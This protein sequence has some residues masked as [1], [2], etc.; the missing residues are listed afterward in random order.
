MLL[1]A[2]TVLALASCGN[3][4]AKLSG[5]LIGADSR[6]IT[7]EM[8]SPGGT[9]TVDTISTDVK[10]RYSFTVK[11]PSQQ[12]TLYNLKINGE[13]IPLFISPGERITVNT[14]FA[15]PRRYTVNGSPES[16]LL[17]EIND[18][19]RNG[20]TRLDS[21]ANA[22]ASIANNEAELEQNTQEYV[23]EYRSTKREHV[24]FIIGNK[25]RLAAVY[26]LNQRMP[27]DEV[28]FAGENDIVYYRTVA[29]EVSRTYP[30]SPYV[31][32]LKREIAAY[33]SSVELAGQLQEKI[34]NPDPF[35]EIAMPDIYGKEQKLSQMLGKV[36]VLDFWSLGFEQAAVV[37]AE[38]RE[39][40]GEFHSR[41]L[42][43]FQVSIDTARPEWV[44]AVQT[45]KL[46][47]TTVFDTK[48]TGSN[49]ARIY[50]VAQVPANYL[51]DASGEIIAR[52]LF[53]DD[54]RKAVE[55]QLKIKN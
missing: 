15:T 23:R 49:A 9:P 3:N 29:D 11:L 54:L 16:E 28:L 13:Y 45:Q 30:E 33:D 52:N 8:V 17:K 35:P 14:F 19:L 38:Y 46:P 26:A 44:N 39:L 10:G 51:I 40:Y 21:I 5:S 42:E 32:A 25:D 27:N 22:R 53:G 7:L 55:N 31:N 6:K 37:N 47:W 41:G 12:A 34:D 18:I 24:R 50:N 43:I 4:K 36:I 1:A 20:T 2:G 48:G